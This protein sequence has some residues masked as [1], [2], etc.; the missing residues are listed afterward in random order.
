MKNVLI[1][2]YYWPPSGSSSVQRVLKF[3]KYLAEFGWRAIVLTVNEGHYSAIDTTFVEE[4]PA[5]V[6]I[7]RVKSIEPHTSYKLFA[8]MK[9][10][11]EI[12]VNV[13]EEKNASWLKKIAFWIRVDLFIPDSRI[14][15]IPFA[16]KQ[17]KKILKNEK[18]DIIFSSAPPA[19]VH[20]IAR[21]LS[22]WAGL[23]WVADFRDPWT[24]IYYKKQFKRFIL[25]K[26]LDEKLEKQVL[27]SA[28]AVTSVSNLD[29]TTDYYPKAPDEKKY[30]YI[31][32]GYD[33][34]DYKSYSSKI[35]KNKKNN[36]III[37]HIGSV[38]DERVPKNLFTAVA[39][40]HRDNIINPNTFNITFIGNNEPSLLAECK[41]RGIEDYIK[42]IAYVPHKHIFAYMQ[43]STVLL[44]LITNVND[45]G[46]I[47]PGKT[48]E[49]LRSGK[50]LLVFG[51]E[52][53]EVATI[54]ERTK[55]GVT[56]DY[57]NYDK[58]YHYLHKLINNSLNDGCKIR[59][60]AQNIEMYSRK[61]LTKNL[62]DVF[63]TLLS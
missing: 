29:L 17:G 60:H 18:I 15:W 11:K 14:G 10:N 42:L 61:N 33:D 2:A 55:S 13:M 25:S 27:Q 24:N 6:K 8:G 31:P 36:K 38:G 9:S 37:T 57:N 53:G 28:D 46:G 7:F 12:P 49:Y 43:E 3:T 58:T 22:K 54:V 40:L 1:I 4:I 41:K 20:L 45:S 26:K 47:V 23:K 35:I 30:Y 5:S 39:V 19:T 44:L 56:I 32:N 62:V 48:F 50:P 51:S 34:D 59:Q 63:N 52:D 21:K 16:I